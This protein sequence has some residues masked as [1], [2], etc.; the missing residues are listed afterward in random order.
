MT[1]SA[2]TPPSSPSD[3]SESLA[4]LRV[5]IDSLDQRLLSLLNE[6]AH[7]AEL[8][9]EVKK[10][11]GTPFFRPD[12]VA[13]V[14]DKMQKSNGGPLKDLHVA[15]IWR[16]IM[17]AC[18][19]LESPQRVAVL[20]PEG[21]FCEQAAID[22]FGGAADLIYCASF[23]EVFHATAA[24]SAQY[25]VVGVE[26]ST[27]GVV[28]RSLDLFLHSPTH[29]V[30]E[31]SL[32]VR[33]HLLR[34]S[35]SLEGVEAVLAHPQALAQCQTWLSKHLP[36]AERRA[37]SSNAEGAR[38][39]ST[40][41]AWAALAGE[42]AATRFGLHIVAHAIQDDS[43]NRTRFSVICLPQ[44][45]AMPPASG[46]DCTSLI[47]SVPNRPGAVH[48]LLVPLKANN[49]SMT[50]FESRPARTGQWE[51]YFYID[52]D[53]HPSQPNVAAALAELRGLCAFYKVLGAYPVKS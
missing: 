43:Y 9:G 26:N 7:V 30:G 29:V 17:S 13:Q 39:A 38:L 1:A 16:E 41:P 34:S 37:V 18:L 24:G 10:R 15:A 11:E 6:R 3:N 44:T 52:L 40:N 49:V 12:R 21:T 19:A 33:H 4:D 27:E 51:Y 45:L 36:N 50:R 47:V 25:G 46:R 48:D 28:T 42:R 20:G 22:Y 8:V 23:D 32:L 5:Q 53:G 2:P 31:V 35:N 14:I